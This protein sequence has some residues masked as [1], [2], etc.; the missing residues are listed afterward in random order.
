M[1]CAAGKQNNICRICAKEFIDLNSLAV[2]DKISTFHEMTE[3]SKKK[4]IS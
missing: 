2:I 3:N 1:W 4:K